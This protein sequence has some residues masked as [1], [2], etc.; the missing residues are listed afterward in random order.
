MCSFLVLWGT[1]AKFGENNVVKS[2]VSGFVNNIIC[3][4]I[5]LVSEMGAKTFKALLGWAKDDSTENIV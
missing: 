5:F 3:G 2:R 1:S 4:L